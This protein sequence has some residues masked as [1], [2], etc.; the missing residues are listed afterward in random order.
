MGE[1]NRERV[2]LTKAMVRPSEFWAIL[3][4]KRYTQMYNNYE[5]R[6]KN[7]NEI[8]ALKRLTHCN[9]EVNFICWSSPRVSTR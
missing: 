9:E 7:T 3:C 2:P 1:K 4:E 6:V 8:T 5:K